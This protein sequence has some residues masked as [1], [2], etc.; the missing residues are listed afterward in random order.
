MRGDL[1]LLND[2]LHLSFEV[3]IPLSFILDLVLDLLQLPFTSGC[4]RRHLIS[5]QLCF[6]QFIDEVTLFLYEF[7]L[8]RLLLVKGFPLQYLILFL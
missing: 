6:L 7:K 8:L 5:I 3:I 1:V 4:L 2:F